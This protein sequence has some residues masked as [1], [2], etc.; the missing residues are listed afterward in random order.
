MIGEAEVC[1][2]GLK[3]SNVYGPS[4]EAHIQELRAD[5]ATCIGKAGTP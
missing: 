3:V 4:F 2:T 5:L 1:G